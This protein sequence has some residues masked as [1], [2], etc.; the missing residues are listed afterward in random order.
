MDGLHGACHDEAYMMLAT[1][2]MQ[3]LLAQDTLQE[4][5][6][7]LFDSS[8][9]PVEKVAFVLQVCRSFD[10]NHACDMNL[11]VLANP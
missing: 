11:H 9:A 1:L 6:V 3:P 7:V 8:G 5:D 4:L 2:T 10:D